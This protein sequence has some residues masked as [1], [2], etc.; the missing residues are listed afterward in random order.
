MLIEAH[1]EVDPT[2]KE[3]TTPLHRAACNGHLKVV[4]ILLD[5]SANANAL[6]VDGN[7]PLDL[8][9]NCDHE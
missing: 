7:S 3:G 9:I 4:K 5:N 1:S 6:D 8:A 2:D